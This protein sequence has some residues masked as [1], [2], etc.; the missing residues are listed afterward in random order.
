LIINLLSIA[1]ICTFSSV[2]KKKILSACSIIRDDNGQKRYIRSDFNICY[3][4]SSKVSTD[5]YDLI[6]HINL[7]FGK[8][9]LVIKWL[10]IFSKLGHY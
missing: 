5:F 2:S 9:M 10:L 3:L 7:A 6:L 4:A 8:K 1:F